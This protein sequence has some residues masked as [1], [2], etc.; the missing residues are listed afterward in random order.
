MATKFIRTYGFV[1][2]VVTFIDL[3]LHKQ[4]IYLTYLLRKLPRGR[5]DK[6]VY[7]ADDVALEYY[8]NQKYLKAALSLR[9][10]VDTT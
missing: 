1:L 3:D 5:G 4:Y 2:Q 6:D 7:L 9:K 10:R 8:R